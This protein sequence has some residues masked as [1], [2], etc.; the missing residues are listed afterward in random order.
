VE[1]IFPLIMILGGLLV[2]LA[3]GLPVAFCFLVINL[4]GGYILWGGID[5]LFNLTYSI[6]SSVA[7]FPLLPVLLF[8]LMGSALFCS[9][10]AVMAVEVVDKWLGR[11]PG[12]LCLVSIGAG[13]LFSSLS[14]SAMGTTA[15]LGTTLLPEMQKRGYHHSIAIGSCMSG[16]LAMII[17]PSALAVVLASCAQVSVGAILIGGVV[18]GLLLAS[19]YSAYIVGRC[20]INP[21]LAP[22]YAVEST[23]FK[24][25]M[26]F[27]LKRLLPVSVLIFVVVGLI[28]LGIATP[29]ESAA[30]GAFCSFFLA[31]ILRKLTWSVTKEIVRETLNVVLMMFLILSGSMAYSQLLAYSGATAGLVQAISVMDVPPMV[32]LLCTQ[33]VILILGTFMEPVSIMMISI[34]I[35]LPVITALGFNTIWFC[36]ITLLNLGI[37]M[38]TPPFGFLLFVMQGL[39]PPNIKITDIY[40]ATLPFIIIDIIGIMLIVIFPIIALWIPNMMAMR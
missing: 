35:F 15:I 5:G 21:K 10:V 34:P 9:G 16:G 6:F 4:I 37:A 12:R 25:K 28:F 31:A 7:T 24:E 13:T 19:L 20:V 26:I 39:T 22:S 3:T 36:L 33:L 2:L 32:I 29:T 27:T 40:K 1:W 17:P 38:K 8:V 14:G 18:P 30:L 23:P 11:L